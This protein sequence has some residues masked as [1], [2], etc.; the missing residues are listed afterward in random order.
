MKSKFAY[1][2]TKLSLITF[3]LI[4]ITSAIIS[5]YIFSIKQY[6]G[7]N[8]RPLKNSPL[9][10]KA[11]KSFL[12]FSKNHNNVLYLFSDEITGLNF[13][14][15]LEANQ[16]LKNNLTDFTFY[17]K[18]FTAGLVTNSNLPAMVGS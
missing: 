12:G 17:N 11:V 15:I 13:K 4:T 16:S 10:Q 7:F 6:D 9:R 2:K 5:F 14:S 18:T 8:Y 3:G 1:L